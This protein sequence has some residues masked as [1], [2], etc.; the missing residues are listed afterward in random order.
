LCINFPS[1]RQ[2]QD[3][4]GAES[5]VDFHL[6]YDS[7]TAMIEKKLG[8]KFKNLD[9][10]K[11]AL[12]HSSY[13][14]E[15]SVESYERLEFLGDAVLDCVVARFLY[16]HFPEASEGKLSKM[17]SAIVSRV[18]FARFAVE[19]GIDKEI[20]LGKGEELT[21]G[22]QRESN[23]AGAFEAV[24]GAVYL[25]GG[26]RKAFQIVSRL[27]KKCIDQKEIFVD[28]KTKL[29]ELI[30]KQY[31]SIPKYK[32]VH[33]EGPPHSKCFHVE[34]RVKRKVLGKGIGR[35]KKEAEQA[36]AREGLE[37]LGFLGQLKT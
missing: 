34:V 31:R 13:A 7:F 23:L 16:D 1:L 27:L 20:L 17:R 9:L 6:A 25:E 10:L 5:L 4:L 32:V 15:T 21:G 33:E 18:N 19:L 24:I 8:Y 36:A 22:R 29:Q 26:Y 37:N 3:K 35:N 14:N 2:A 11:T 12:T 28:Y 30:Q